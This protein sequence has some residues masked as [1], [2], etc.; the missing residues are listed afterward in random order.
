EAFLIVKQFGADKYEIVTP[1]LS[2]LAEPPV[3]VVDKV[4][5]KH[6]TRKVAE[7]YLQYLYSEEAQEII[8]KNFY[9]PR[10]EKVAQ[11]Y[12]NAFPKLTL[13][14]I[15]QSFGGWTKAQKA[16]FDDGGFYDQIYGAGR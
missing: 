14:T 6:G 8:A 16:H 9:R 2:I 3:A 4:A 13:V 12:A 7:A 10:N 15:D 1:S 5:D 11:K